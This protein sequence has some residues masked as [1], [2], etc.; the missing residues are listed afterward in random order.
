MSKGINF[1]RVAFDTASNI[2][3]AIQNILN[4]NVA[5]NDKVQKINETLNLVGS[6]FY[7]QMFNA[8]SQ[9]FDSEAIGTTD[10][11]EMADQV[12]RLARKIVRNDSLGRDTYQLVESFYD[13]ALGR[14]QGEAFKN[15]VSLGKHPILTRS[16]VGKCCEWCGDMAGVHKNPTPDLFA[17]HAHCDCLFVTSG[18][19][20]RNG[21][22][23]NYIKNPKH[24]NLSAYEAR[25]KIGVTQKYWSKE[26]NDGERWFAQNYP[27]QIKWINKNKTDQNGKKL[28]T[29]DYKMLINNKEF[30]LKTP[31]TQKAKSISR[32]ISMAASK[33]KENFMVNLKDTKLSDSLRKRLE[34]YNITHP[35]NKR[36]KEIRVF[37][38][39]GE[40][41]IGL[42]E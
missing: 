7:N 10:Y 5:P 33:G 29:N 6:D 11:N 30:E 34:E 14:A 26:M 42:R 24:A 8:N 36:I 28:P 23:H 39:E 12:E 35:S 27:E 20:T 21:A 17:R 41:L 32:T 18:Y 13:S 25:K 16:T 40:T 31:T 1:S 3:P 9:V 37:T 38:K 19:R 4:L 15:A 2:H 22:L